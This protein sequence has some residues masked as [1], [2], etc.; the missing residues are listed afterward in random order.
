MHKWMVGIGLA[1]A[2]ASPAYASSFRCG[3]HLVTEG[4]TRSEVVSKCGEPTELDRRTAI[5]RRPVVWIR[6]RPVVVGE[7]LIEVPV[8]VWVYNLGP[9]KLMRRLRFEDGLLV[10]VDT[11]GYGYYENQPPPSQRDDG[12]NN[13][14]D[15]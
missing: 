7:S 15:R 1:L 12:R 13:D 2:A 9:N 14:Q 4:D 10:D 11:L 6:G 8:E 3:T 5:L